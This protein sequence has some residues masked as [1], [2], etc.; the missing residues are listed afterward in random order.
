MILNDWLV[1]EFRQR[2]SRKRKITITD[3]L[4]RAFKLADIQVSQAEEE[5]EAGLIEENIT[6]KRVKQIFFKNLVVVLVPSIH[7]SIV[8]RSRYDAI[9]NCKE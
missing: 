4:A 5:Q 6:L 8:R 2:V 9:L 1:Q 3:R 7:N